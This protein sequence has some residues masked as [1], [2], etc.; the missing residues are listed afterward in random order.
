MTSTEYRST[1]TTALKHGTEFLAQLAELEERTGEQE[2]TNQ[3][4]EVREVLA[5]LRGW[6]AG[7]FQGTSLGAN[8]TR[9]EATRASRV[10]GPA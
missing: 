6:Q 2:L 4:A 7:F 9:D 8:E 10:L 5:Y 3:V 1:V